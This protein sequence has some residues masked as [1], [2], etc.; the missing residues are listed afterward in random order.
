MKVEDRF[1]SK[2]DIRGPDECWNWNASSSHRGGG[3]GSFWIDGKIVY[4]H[5]FAWILTNGDIPDGL[6]VLHKVECHNKGCCN[7]NHLYLGTNSDNQKDS[8]ENGT[9]FFSNNRLLGEKAS[10]SKLTEKQVREFLFSHF[11]EGISTKEIAKN[12]KVTRQAL[13][14]ILEGKCWKEVFKD[15]KKE[16]RIY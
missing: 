11:F 10:N 8:I 9:C 6:W 7:P 14:G 4:S 15:F 2:V 5:R 13:D 1:W 16:Y 3:Y 12:Y